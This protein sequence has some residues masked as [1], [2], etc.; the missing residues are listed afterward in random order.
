M[1]DIQLSIIYIEI[2]YK[3]SNSMITK[4]TY[5][6]GE[7]YVNMFNQNMTYKLVINSTSKILD[8]IT[9]KYCF[10]EPNSCLKAIPKFTDRCTLLIATN[11]K[12]FV[13]TRF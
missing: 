12:T 11:Y 7:V 6:N 2:R 4:I 1:F 8:K 3:I 13:S 9:E 10:R 5:F